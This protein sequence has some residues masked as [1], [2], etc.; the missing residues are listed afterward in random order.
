MIW[1]DSLS[2]SLSSDRR[3]LIFM[4]ASSLVGTMNFWSA[5]NLM[6]FSKFLIVCS[7]LFF[8][9]SISMAIIISSFSSTRSMSA[10]SLNGN[11]LFGSL[12]CRIFSKKYLCSNPWFLSLES[13]FRSNFCKQFSPLSVSSK[14]FF[15]SIVIGVIIPFSIKVFWSLVES[16][17][18]SPS[19]FA[20]LVCSIKGVSEDVFEEDSFQWGGSKPFCRSV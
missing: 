2:G 14:S 18:M 20:S 1:M 8:P 11:Q 10:F 12:P 4:K 15:L 6:S 7:G 16:L 17:G 5:L 13:I 3:S 9:V 19:L